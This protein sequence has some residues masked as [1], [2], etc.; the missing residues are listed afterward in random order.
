[1]RFYEEEDITMWWAEFLE[2][3]MDSMLRRFLSLPRREL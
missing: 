1:M 2:P 3:R